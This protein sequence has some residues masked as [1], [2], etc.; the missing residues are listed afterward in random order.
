MGSSRVRDSG[1]R[2]YGASSVAPVLKLDI[3]RCSVNWRPRGGSYPHRHEGIA[4][5]AE[6]KFVPQLF[7]SLVTRVTCPK[8]DSKFS[9]EEGFA[10]QALEKLEQSTEGALEAVREGERAQ[11]LKQA[12]QLATQR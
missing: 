1:R 6:P 11:A 5:S 3:Q 7:L 10:R 12:Q 2:H 8:C 4:V 9:L